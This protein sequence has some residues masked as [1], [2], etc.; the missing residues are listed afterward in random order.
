MEK[1]FRSHPYIN[2]FK[3]SIQYRH[4]NIKKKWRIKLVFGHKPPL[5]T[6][7]KLTYV[8]S[9]SVIFYLNTNVP[10]NSTKM[11][12][13]SLP[14]LVQALKYKQKW[15]VKLVF[16]HKPPLLTRW[17]IS[18]YIYMYIF[19]LCY[20]PSQ[21]KCTYINI[22]LCRSIVWSLKPFCT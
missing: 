10:C 4:L 8:Y 11:P 7:W 13:N 15:R 21:H 18:I 5:L 6:R 1:G 17:N 3:N 19:L 9:F 16:G 12:S 2:R 14:G 22:L 20:L